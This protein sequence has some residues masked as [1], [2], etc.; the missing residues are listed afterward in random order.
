MD[1]TVDDE[2]LNVDDDKKKAKDQLQDEWLMDSACSFYICL[3]E[4]FDVIEGRK[5]KK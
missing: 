1:D 5:E 4:G 2:C 3:K